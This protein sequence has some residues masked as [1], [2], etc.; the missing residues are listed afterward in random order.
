LYGCSLGAFFSIHAYRDK[1]FENCIF[2]SPIV[3]MEYLIEQMF[4]WFNITEEQL[5]IQGEIQTPIDTMKW[6]YYTYV[7]EHSIDKWNVPTHILYGAKDNLQSYAVI[8]A[9]ADKYNCF[10]TV[11]DN[12]EHPFMEESDKEIVKAWMDNSI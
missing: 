8:K 5:R 1:H 3:D 6:L 4:V 2:Q 12:S 7:K 11:S 10:L 9:F